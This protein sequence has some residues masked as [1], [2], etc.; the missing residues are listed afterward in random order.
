MIAS[1]IN[2]TC[3]SLNSKNIKLIAFSPILCD[4]SKMKDSLENY[5]KTKVE[6]P[7]Q[8]ELGEILDIFKQ[9]RFEKKE[10]IKRP[11]TISKE[12]GFLVK[13]S[14]KGAFY[15]T[16]G[17]EA[18]FRLLEENSFVSD[19]IS[20]TTKEPTPIAFEC[21]NKVDM[22]IAPI[23]KVHTL[24]KSNLVF[25]IVVREYI[26]ENAVQMGRRHLSFLTGS[27]KDRYLFILENQ[28]NLLKKFPLRVIASLI[29]IT[30]TQLSRIRN[31]NSI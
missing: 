29:G 6:N 13:G 14:V 15:K 10:F 7:S 18:T 12:V 21:I 22:L 4:Y 28:P 24:L 3:K 9:R 31:K 16:N 17:K 27:A 19:A 1:I 23:E 11:F 26:T 8:K 30:P 5:I 25:N 2:C 20:T